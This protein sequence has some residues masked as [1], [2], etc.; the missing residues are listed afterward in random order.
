MKY[1]QIT[2]ICICS[3]FTAI[4]QENDK[5]AVE[6]IVVKLFEGMY[7]SDS[8]QVRSLFIPQVKMAT[9]ATDAQGNSVVK[10]GGTLQD[11]LNAIGTK[12]TE[13]LSEEIW[14]IKVNVDGGLAQAWCDYAFYV[15]K[16]FSHCGADAFH[17]VK[18]NGH[19]KIFQ[20]A[21]TRRR[22]NCVI[23]EAIQNKFK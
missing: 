3:F 21:D 10:D 4:A 15:G 9:I 12:R 22:S 6:Q 18:E 5:M 17:L 14:N 7:K 2:L 8:A 16:K 1:I 19:W 23:P 11:F 20:L 13:K